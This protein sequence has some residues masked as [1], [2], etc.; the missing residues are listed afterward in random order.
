MCM[1]VSMILRTFFLLLVADCVGINPAQNEFTE[2]WFKPNNAALKINLILD[3]YMMIVSTQLENLKLLY[4][5]F[6]QNN[7]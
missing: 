5:F 1:Y 2:L 4:S 6:Y 3:G 7:F